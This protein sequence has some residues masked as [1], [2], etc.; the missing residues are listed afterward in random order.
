R[1]PVRDRVLQYPLVVRGVRSEDRHDQVR[2]LGL[3]GPDVDVEDVTH[4]L[5]GQLHG[6]PS[7]SASLSGASYCVWASMRSPRDAESWRR[8]AARSASVN[9]SGSSRT[10]FHGPTDTST[11]PPNPVENPSMSVSTGR[12]AS[13]NVPKYRL[14]LLDFQCPTR[15]RLAICAARSLRN[16]SARPSLR[17]AGGW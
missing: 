3:P 7:M 16:G 9:E 17:G 14:W 1:V 8:T 5:L 4:V 6:S 10:H 15:G 13:W 2:V 11:S 12:T